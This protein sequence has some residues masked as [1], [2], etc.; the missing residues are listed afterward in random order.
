MPEHSWNWK[1]NCSEE[2]QEHQEQYTQILLKQN[3]NS[4]TKHLFVMWVASSSLQR[5]GGEISRHF[6]VLH[7]LHLP[8]AFRDPETDT[9]AIGEKLLLE[10]GGSFLQAVL[11]HRRRRRSH[12]RI[13]RKL[14]GGNQIQIHGMVR[15]RDQRGPNGALRVIKIKGGVVWEF[16]E[17]LFG[18]QWLQI[19]HHFDQSLLLLVVFP[20]PHIHLGCSS[21]ELW[22][23]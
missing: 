21:S 6:L 3:Q 16:A 10:V 13:G 9:D 17:K 11:L 15:P 14:D 23:S 19:L 20:R 4:K 7:L 12:F 18:H 22:F 1:L 8:V 5:L 2:H